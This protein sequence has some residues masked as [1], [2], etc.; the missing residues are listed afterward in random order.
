MRK[1]GGQAQ[2]TVIVMGLNKGAWGAGNLNRRYIV[3][4][5]GRRR[6]ERKGVAKR[7]GWGLLQ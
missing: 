5:V 3:R 2:A 6:G 7:E 1:F 4:R